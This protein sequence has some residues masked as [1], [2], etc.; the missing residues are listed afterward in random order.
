VVANRAAGLVEGTISMDAIE[1]NLQQGME[2]VRA[3]L[4]EVVQV[5]LDHSH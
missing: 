2:R 4:H 3:L 1:A 5:D